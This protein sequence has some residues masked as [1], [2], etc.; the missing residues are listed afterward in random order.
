MGSGTRG[1]V[2]SGFAEFDILVGH[3]SGDALGATV[4][5]KSQLI[6]IYKYLCG[7]PQHIEATES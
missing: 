3:P 5:R 6:P 2:L 4:W 1:Q 7:C